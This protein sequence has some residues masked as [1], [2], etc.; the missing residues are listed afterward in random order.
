[1]TTNDETQRLIRL[2]AAAALLPQIEAGFADGKISRE[3]AALSAEFCSWAV[4]ETNLDCQ[5]SSD[6]ARK[7]DDGLQRLKER[8]ST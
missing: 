7:I 4:A 6:L 1:M 5:E 8:L 2:R 3:K